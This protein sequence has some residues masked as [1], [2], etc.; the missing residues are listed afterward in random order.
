MNQKFQHPR[1]RAEEVHKLILM[2]EARVLELEGLIRTCND[3]GIKVLTQQTYLLNKRLLDLY[4]AS[5]K[6][7]LGL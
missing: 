1:D 3:Y 7:L 6:R 5:H 2:L 4:K